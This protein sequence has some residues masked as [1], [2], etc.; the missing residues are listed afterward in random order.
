M[1]GEYN[2]HDEL[3]CILQ[4]GSSEPRNLP[5]E[6][7]RKITNNFADDRLLGEGG[8]GKVYK[9]VLQNGKLVAVKKLDQLIKLGIQE[10]QFENEVYHL[11]RLKHP[12][13][14]RFIG[15]CYETRNECVLLN[16]K[17]IFAEIQHKLICL[18]YM[19]NG[20]LDKHLSDE[21]S[22]HDWHTRYKII[23]GICCGLH[24]L[25]EECQCQFSASIIHLDLKPANILLDDN[26][27]P[28]VADFGLSRLFEDDKTHTCATFISGSL[29]YMAPEYLIGRIVTTKADVYNLGVI[30]M[31]IITGSKVNIFSYSSPTSWQDFVECVLQNWRNRLQA[32]PSETDCKQIKCCLEIGLDCIKLNREERPTAREIIERLERF[33]NTYCYIDNKERPPSDQADISGTRSNAGADNNDYTGAPRS[34]GSPKWTSA[35]GLFLWPLSRTIRRMAQQLSSLFKEAANEFTLAQLEEATFGFALEA[36][37]GEGSFGTVYHGKLPNGREV[38]IKR[39]ESGPYARPFQ[40]SAFRSELAFFS[41]YHHKHIVGL[42]GYCEEN[43]ERIL[44]YEYMKNG[45]LYDQLHS[46]AATLW[47]PVVSSSWERHIK[48]L[49]DASRGIQYLHSDDADKPPIIHRDI[50]SSSILLDVGWT[51][52]VSGFG[53]S[54][55]ESEAHAH[56]MNMEAAV[57]T[58]GYIDPEYYSRHYLS[59]KSDVYAFGVVMLEVLTGKRAFFGEAEGRSPGSVVDYAVPSIVA[60]EM[61]KVLD[62]RAPEPDEHEAEAV[63]L[64]AYTAVHCVRLEGKDRPTMDDIVANLETALALCEKSLGLSATDRMDPMYFLCERRGEAT[65]RRR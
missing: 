40:E 49:L 46:K 28:K 19:P 2:T 48:I 23:K 29:G 47:S 24:Y 6:Y 55:M 13:I 57:G 52:R 54:L 20:S 61:D 41:H 37:I 34:C 39:S 58:V 10:R 45:S 51:A 8:F 63:K 26:M 53:L 15:Y 36:K 50:K 7:L 56:L 65:C 18:E 35:R 27:G 22:G 59:V 14:V 30:I 32:T 62:P 5:L 38:A 31:E 21:S 64:V 33:E 11:I 43:K 12:N 44:V 17:H 1:D 3:D 4:D 9:G 60:G 16:G 42:V 25:H